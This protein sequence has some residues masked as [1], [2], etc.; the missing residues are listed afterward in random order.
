MTH[1]ILTW[2]T[3]FLLYQPAFVTCINSDD[4]LYLLATPIQVITTLREE[5]GGEKVAWSLSLQEWLHAPFM[6]FVSLILL[7]YSNS[8]VI[9][10][11]FVATE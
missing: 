7:D 9:H 3:P 10:K 2:M 1:A 11:I 4:V 6:F 8:K 5:R